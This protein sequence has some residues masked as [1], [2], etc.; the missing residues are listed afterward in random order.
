MIE[1]NEHFIIKP[2]KN[3]NKFELYIHSKELRARLTHCPLHLI[4]EDLN[5]ITD[6]SKK[7]LYRSIAYGQI[8]KIV[9]LG[10][11]KSNFDTDYSMRVKRYFEEKLS[12]IPPH[13]DLS[14]DDVK[15]GYYK[16]ILKEISSI[17]S[18]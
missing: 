12:S 14:K 8:L 2:Y 15:E 10:Y 18:G 16:H 11:E 6:F 13:I 5:S 3:R 9:I 17:I 7:I 4:K 1:E